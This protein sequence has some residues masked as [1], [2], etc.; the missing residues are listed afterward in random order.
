MFLSDIMNIM[1]ATDAANLDTSY[2]SHI[3]WIILFP[4][5]AAIKKM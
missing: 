3:R 5:E 2:Y 1:T 4:F